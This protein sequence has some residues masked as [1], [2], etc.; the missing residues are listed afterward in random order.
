MSIGLYQKRSV[1]TI[2]DNLKPT[3]YKE[4]FDEFI[5]SLLALNKTS[6]MLTQNDVQLLN[7]L[8]AQWESNK[9]RGIK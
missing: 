8:L 9:Q 1:D 7:G 6:K 5:R 2:V 3:D 4:R